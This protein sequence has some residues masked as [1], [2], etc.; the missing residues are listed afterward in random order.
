MI[1]LRIRKCWTAHETAALRLA[2][3][4]MAIAAVIWL[5]YEFWRLLW[6]PGYWGAIDLRVLQ[7]AVGRWVGGIDVYIDGSSGGLYPPASY[8]LLWP[9]MG[10]LVS[11]ELRISRHKLTPFSSA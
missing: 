9:F 8:L 2:I 6:E 1:I 3:I 10:W 5:S 7:N 11:R 4:I